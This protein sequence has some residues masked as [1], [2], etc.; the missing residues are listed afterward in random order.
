MLAIAGDEDSY[1]RPS[2]YRTNN[3]AGAS[4]SILIAGEGHGI[5]GLTETREAI[6]TF[7][8]ECCQ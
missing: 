4:K 3:R 2:S 7:L 8:R 5:L 1:A 6:G